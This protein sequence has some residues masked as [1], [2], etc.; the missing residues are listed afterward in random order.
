MT[1][2][3]SGAVTIPGVTT[4]GIKCYY[5]FQVLVLIVRNPANTFSYT[6]TGAAIAAART[7]NLP[8]ITG[9]DTLASLLDLL[10]H[11]QVLKHSTMQSV[12]AGAATMAIFN[13]TATNISFAGAATTL[14]IGAATGTATIAKMPQ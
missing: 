7:L 8:L 2:A 6:I 10:K 1:I 5:S 12:L 14:A 4:M 3:S 9:T 11:G 13:T